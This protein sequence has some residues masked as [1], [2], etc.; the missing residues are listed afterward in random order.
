MQYTD[1]ELA[2]IFLATT[3]GMTPARYAKF[4]SGYPD[5]LCAMRDAANLPYAIFG[6]QQDV[7][8]HYLQD[9]AAFKNFL[10]SVGEKGII[11]LTKSSQNYP[12]VLQE[13]D[14]APVMLYARGNV[15]RLN[16]ALQKSIT[17]VGS[18]Q[19]TRYGET[20][21]DM[22]SG[23]LAA[24]GVTIVSGLAIGVDAHAHEGA[25]KAGGITIGIVSGGADCGVPSDNIDLAQRILDADGVILSEYA[26]GTPVKP[27]MFAQRNRI[28]SGLTCGTVLIQ[29]REKSGAMITVDHAQEQGK[30]I[31]A[32]PGEIT[33][34]ASHGP[35]LLIQ[36]GAVPV[37]DVQ[38]ILDELRWG[39]A[40]AI[41][42][43]KKTLDWSDRDETE[44][45]ILMALSKGA[46]SMENLCITT[47]LSMQTMMSY[48]TSLEM[49]GIIEQFPGRIVD[50]SE[51]YR[52]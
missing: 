20:V 50:I 11:C 16:F 48:L 36:H 29:A 33:Q 32:V 22:L 52:P 30:T 25:L 44:R 17:I 8:R 31:F 23:E 3:P 51:A 40:A 5:A 38:D 13:L 47:K 15:E 14:D 43:G 28:L 4:T 41:S 10:K 49:E 39:S 45:T 9:K 19:P 18:R 6:K 2:E 37:L 46:L 26:P 35:N 42:G 1:I 12:H 34:S 24:C 27:W 21:A 7:A